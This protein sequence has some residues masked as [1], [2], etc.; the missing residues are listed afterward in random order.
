MADNKNLLQQYVKIARDILNPFVEMLGG[1]LEDRKEGLASL[2]LDP[3]FANSS[4]AVPTASLNSINQYVEKSADEVDEIAFFAVLEDLI[5]IS[6]VIKEFFE[7]ASAGNPNL[8]ASELTTSYMNLLTLNYLR[9]RAPVFFKVMSIIENV[10]QQSVRSG[11][12]LN[13]FG[14][15]GKF[16][17]NV[18]EGFKLENEDHARNLSDT[19]LFVGGVGLTLL[20]K[21]FFH[22]SIPLSVDAAYGYDTYPA[23]TSPNAD[24]LSQRTLSFSIKHEADTVE[25]KLTNTLVL[26]PLEQQGKAAVMDITG[27]VKVDLDLGNHWKFTFDTGGLG[28]IF[29]VGEGADASLATNPFVEMILE[30]NTD[31]VTKG[32]LFA[33]PV[34]KFGYGRVKTSIRFSKDDIEWKFKPTI[35]FEFGRGTK[36]SFPFT[37]IPKKGLDQKIDIAIGISQKKGFFLDG[38]AN[39]FTIALPVYATL[40][41]VSFDVITLAYSSDEA[42]KDKQIEVSISFKLK[43]GSVIAATVSRTG[44]LAVLKKNPNGEGAIAG[45]DIDFSF[46][47]PNGIGVAVDAGVVTGG[48]FLYFDAK[49]GEYFGALELSFKNLFTFKAIGIINTKMPD[50]SDGYSLLIIVT[51]SGFSFQL[52]FGFTLNG[53]GG[54]LGLHRTIKVDVLVDGLKTNTLKSILFPEDVVANINRIISDLKQ[55]FPIQQDHFVVGLMAKIGW[56]T[57]TLVSLDLG[58]IVDFPDPRVVILGVLKAA[59]PKEDAAVL[60]LQIN[61]IGIIDIPNSFI[62]FRADLYDSRL[63]AFTLTGSLALLVAWG[64]NATFALSVGGFHPDFHDIPTIPQLPNGFKNLDRLGISLLSGENPRITI[65]CYFAVTS[66]TVQFGAKAELYA[67]AAGFNVYGYLGF[68]V[69]FQFEPFHFI[70]KLYAG[71]AL[72]RGTS[73]I[74]GITVS[75]ELSGP[76]PWDVKG[77]AS[78]SILF[79]DITIGF[80]V[81]WGDDPDAVA[82]ITEDLQK[83]MIDEINNNQNWQAVI[84]DNNKLHVS[85]KDLKLIQPEENPSPNIVIHPLG[86]LTFSERV[87]P[88]EVTIQKFGTRVP[89]DVDLFKI[90]GV[91]SGTTTLSY[92]AAK[93][94]FAPANFFNLKDNEKLSR[95]SF[96]TNVSGCKVTATADLSIAP[97]VN[98]SVDYEMSYLRKKRFALFFAGIYKY[99]KSLFRSNLK[100]NAVA[101]S[102]MSYATNRQSV[103]APDAVTVQKDQYVVANVSDMKMHSAGMVANSYAEAVEMYN[104]LTAKKPSLKNKVQILS[105]YEINNN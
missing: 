7:A 65:Q 71:L 33:N 29:R 83:L 19:M 2:G 34:M 90:N 40:G 80:H 57:P 50:G 5:K 105:Q 6:A 75:G 101:K 60:K 85:V 88:M 96:E 102:K 20:N 37:L 86:V 103:N 81:T 76:K 94:R 3:S 8:T 99:S 98:K 100:G 11:G 52:G 41:P 72:R 64:D 31:E 22:F 43:I 49:A 12:I 104:T 10:D 25:S 9:L 32:T 62:F 21:L 53:L 42:T 58:V 4:P 38:G 30:N 68:D 35:A 36:T 55:V 28:I 14:A 13:L 87:L 18:G 59:L 69:L 97:A 44:V 16:F 78:F 63:L 91:K 79:F 46:K 15:I 26:V 56:G 47:P 67:E 51:A 93:E 92:D 1:T 45:H 66:N 61:F 54:L 24:M 23:S 73:V 17:E 82:K 74:K 95:R 48:G 77:E 70:A 27:E 84:P 89:K 39:G